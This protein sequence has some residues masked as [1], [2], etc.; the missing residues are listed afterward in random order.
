[1]HVLAERHFSRAPRRKYHR[2]DPSTTASIT[3]M[4]TKQPLHGEEIARSDKQR[5]PTNA[6][7]ADG[8]FGVVTARGSD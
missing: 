8:S 7:P 4:T 1:L 3:V 2:I 6:L 5:I